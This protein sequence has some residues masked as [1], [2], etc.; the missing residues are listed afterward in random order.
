[1]IYICHGCVLT[2]VNIT[3]AVTDEQVARGGLRVGVRLK[4]EKEE[5]G[6]G[7]KVINMLLLFCRKNLLLHSTLLKSHC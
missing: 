4:E 2:C 7:G 1:M 6:W 5:G 3:F